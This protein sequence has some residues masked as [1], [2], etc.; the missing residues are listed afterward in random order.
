MN[1][2]E[3]VKNV[4]TKSG[5][6][7]FLIAVLLTSTFVSSLLLNPG[8]VRS[9]PASHVVISE[10]QLAGGVAGDEFVELYNP[11][12]D[13][14][15]MTGWR[16]S[17]KTGAGTESSL[18]S[19]ISG[20]IPANGYFLIT[21][22]TEYDGATTADATYSDTTNRLTADNSVLLYQDA[23]ITLV[24]KVG[25]G[26]AIDNETAATLSP[27]ANG[28]VERKP[29][30]SVATGGNG[31]DSDNNSV[32][33]Q[34]RTTSEPQN[35]ASATEEPFVLPSTPPSITISLTPTLT[36]TPTVSPSP[37]PEPSS[38][39]TPT[40]TPTAE[41]TATL[42]PTTMPTLTPSVTPT[43]TLTPSPSPSPTN[44]PTPTLVPTNSPTVTLTPSPTVTVTPV[45]SNTSTPTPINTST[46][47][48]LLTLT[49]TLTP[50]PKPAPAGILIARF[51]FPGSEKTLC[52]LE[53]KKSKLLFSFLFLPQISCSKS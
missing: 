31:E 36:L 51:N 1:L 46:P 48:P 14:V 33:F 28:S 5:I 16:L 17:R 9:A 10:V 15:N 39:L 23:S 27:S 19:S 45:P 49:P 41:P 37:S 50:T 24:D 44:T 35:T 53:F 29:G 3:Y 7:Y 34:L 26:T 30:E 52:R 13:S 47:T 25:I 42:T 8:F 22:P 32:D 2:N 20:T 11:T 6:I 40:V 43:F 12:S 38:T 4:T 18:V 21:P